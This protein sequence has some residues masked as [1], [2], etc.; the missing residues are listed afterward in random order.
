MQFLSQSVKLRF[1]LDLWKHS[2]GNASV[3]TLGQKTKGWES[4]MVVTKLKWKC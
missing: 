2:V 4:R 1:L 3:E